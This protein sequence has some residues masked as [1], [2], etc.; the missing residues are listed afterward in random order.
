MENTDRTDGDL[1]GSDAKLDVYGDAHSPPIENEEWLAFI[2]L[3][4]QEVVDG[5]LDSLKDSNL[6]FKYRRFHC[7]FVNFIAFFV[8]FIAFLFQYVGN[9]LFLCHTYSYF[10]FTHCIYP[11]RVMLF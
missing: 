3:T 1:S 4:M 5:E 11:I 9:L 8:N 6:V 7:I 10:V 2:Y